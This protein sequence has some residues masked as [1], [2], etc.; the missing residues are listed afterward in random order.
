MTVEHKYPDLVIRRET[1]VA[2]NRLFQVNGIVGLVPLS[3]GAKLTNAIITVAGIARE[4]GIEK[5][6]AFL[7]DDFRQSMDLLA[8][9]LRSTVTTA[10]NLGALI[11]VTLFVGPTGTI[12]R[13][14]GDQFL[15]VIGEGHGAVDA[16]ARYINRGGELE[17]KTPFDFNEASYYIWVDDTDQFMNVMP[18]DR[19][20]FFARAQQRARTLERLGVWQENINEAGVDF[21]YIDVA[22]AWRAEVANY[23][24]QTDNAVR[25]ARINKLMAEA[26]EAQKGFLSAYAD[27]QRAS[28]EMAKANRV[29]KVLDAASN[30]S[31][32]ITSATSLA[33]L[34]TAPGNQS[35]ERQ[36]PS[37]RPPRS[38]AQR[39]FYRYQYEEYSMMRGDQRII[40][41]RF[42]GVIKGHAEELGALMDIPP[43]TRP[44]IVKEIPLY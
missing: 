21:D 18:E 30:V 37:D 14:P 44:E 11:K 9:E 36:L 12:V 13:V 10:P 7:Q 42:E 25:L 17:A 24:A 31:S 15:T 38:E 43:G 40:M 4:I 41:R 27:Y 6:E 19:Q 2:V 35:V 28:A 33:A 34:A 5:H 32:L 1:P 8:T 39:D 22:A 26:E 29:A 3:G 16:M 23:A 20:G